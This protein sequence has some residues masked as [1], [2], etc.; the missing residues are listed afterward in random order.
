MIGLG[1]TAVYPFLA[2]ETIE[3]LC[4]KGE[5]DISP[6]QATLNYRKG[7]N[8]GLALLL[9]T[10]ALNCLKQWVLTTK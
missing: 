10:V 2:Y 5:L 9:A 8:K 3:Q 1:A 4:E 7:I 6:M